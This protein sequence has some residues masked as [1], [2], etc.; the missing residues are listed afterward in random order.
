MNAIDAVTSTRV[1]I[2]DTARSCQILP[3][4]A[5]VGVFFD[6]Q[7]RARLVNT[8]LDPEVHDHNTVCIC[9]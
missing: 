8:L 4:P 2:T 1:T 5:D 7:H 9:P 3:Y 6:W